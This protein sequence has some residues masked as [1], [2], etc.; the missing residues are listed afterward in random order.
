MP[1]ASTSFPTEHSEM[2]GS[3]NNLLCWKNPAVNLDCHKSVG[4]VPY[5]CT[6]HEHAYL[7]SINRA[8]IV[9]L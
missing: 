2:K 5:T 7:N 9:V 1:Q 8:H 3:Q 6:S 4:Y